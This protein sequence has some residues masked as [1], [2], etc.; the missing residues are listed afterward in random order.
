MLCQHLSLQKLVVCS[1][2]RSLKI[3]ICLFEFFFFHTINCSIHCIRTRS[4][5]LWLWHPLGEDQTVLVF[6][7]FFLPVQ[8]GKK[9][10][11]LKGQQLVQMVLDHEGEKFVVLETPEQE[12]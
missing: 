7:S 9:K 6:F 10:A 3:P 2:M 8:E 12:N 5:E 11:K 1:G 4:F